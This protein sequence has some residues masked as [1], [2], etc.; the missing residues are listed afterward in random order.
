MTIDKDDFVAAG[1]RAFVKPFGGVIRLEPENGAPIW[2]DGRAAPP[3]FRAT[4][5]KGLD[6]GGA[7]QCVWRGSRETLIRIFE[8][9]R[10]LGSS[11]LS[12]RLS[13]SGDMSVMAR[14]Q[15]ERAARG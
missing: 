9:E 10:L 4:A 6:S 7:G 13:I 14:L 15:L 3:K 5:P 8:G 2:V 12:G 1:E 11:Y